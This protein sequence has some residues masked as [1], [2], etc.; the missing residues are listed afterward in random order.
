MKVLFIGDIVAKPGRALIKDVL[1]EIRE[2]YAPDLILA[3]AENLTHGNGFSPDHIKELQKA[4]VDFFSSGDHSWGNKKGMEKLDDKNFPVIRP[5]NYPSENVPGRGYAIVKSNSG[6]KVLFINLIGRVFMKRDY[7]CPFRTVDRILKETADE[8]FDAIIVDF[9]AEA[10]SEKYAM[11]F[12]LDGRVSAVLG[13]HTHV[14]TA[15]ARVLDEGTAVMTDVGM[16]GSYDSVIGV[17]KE[18]ILD[19]FLTQMP[20]KYEPETAGKMVFNAAI[21]ELDEKSSKALNVQHVQ[22]IIE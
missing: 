5:A 3:N 21:I 16:S 14:P 22:K 10:S 4:G 13:T 11:G 1:P 7:D 2:E 6:D 18:V 20:F 17:K 9:H 8:K 19:S 15:D 12:Y